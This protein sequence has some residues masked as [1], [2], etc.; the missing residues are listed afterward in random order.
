MILDRPGEFYCKF[1]KNV[2]N[3]NDTV[4]SRYALQQRC[5]LG[6]ILEGDRAI[7][8]KTIHLT[9]FYLET[10]YCHARVRVRARVSVW[11]R[12]MVGVRMK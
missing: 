4:I 3:L 12:V 1:E 6:R 5:W 7:H 8:L 9:L 10:D 11:V 2:R